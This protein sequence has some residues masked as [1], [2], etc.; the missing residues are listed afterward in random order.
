MSYGFRVFNSDGTVQ[1]DSEG[2]G[3]LFIDDFALAANGSVTKTYTGLG[4]T[5]LTVSAL[6]VSSMSSGATITQAV[7]GSDK[8][9]TVSTTGSGRFRIMAE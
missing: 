4:S 7:V 9:V 1:I 8:Q 5:T 6:G 3:M 2:I